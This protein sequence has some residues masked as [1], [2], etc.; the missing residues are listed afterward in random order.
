MQLPSPLSPSIYCAAIRSKHRQTLP[1]RNSSALS[2]SFNRCHV[3]LLTAVSATPAQAQTQTIPST[4]AKSIDD[5]E[6]AFP[7]P[8]DQQILILILGFSKKS[9]DVCQVWAKHIRTEMVEDPRVN[10]YQIA[11]LEG[12]PSL[13]KR[14]IL[15][16]IRSG[17]SPEQQS[18]FIPLY[19][20]EDQ[21]KKLV[22][23]SAPDD[24]YLI[25]ASPE[26]QITW[27]FH[28]PFT[29]ASYAE[30]KNAASTLLKKM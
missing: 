21:W 12:V 24:P 27:Q 22:N 11:S 30:L 29:D 28:G 26:G 3:L 2:Q 18:H 9:G 5:S 1:W 7:R 16:G 4:K 14:I 25:V 10:Y 17:L 15:H 19:D 8:A 23:F 13:A 20:N 6:V